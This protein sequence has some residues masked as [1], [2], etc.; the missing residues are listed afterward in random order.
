MSDKYVELSTLQSNQDFFSCYYLQYVDLMHGS[1][2]HH[3]QGSFVPAPFPCQVVEVLIKETEIQAGQPILKVLV[4]SSYVPFRTSSS[5]DKAN[6][7]NAMEGSSR[8]GIY[9]LEYVSVYHNASNSSPSTSIDYVE[10]LKRYENFKRFDVVVDDSDHLFLSN[11]SAM[12]HV[13]VCV[14]IGLFSSY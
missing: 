4:P 1:D 2:K 5:V 6:Y 8:T 13:S 10:I 7:K 14:F 3:P 12:Q 11:R 9:P